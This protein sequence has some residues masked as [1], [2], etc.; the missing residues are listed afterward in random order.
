MLACSTLLKKLMAL[1]ASG[2]DISSTIVKSFSTMPE[3]NVKCS[4]EW[5]EPTKIRYT[6]RLL[7][8]KRSSIHLL[9]SWLRCPPISVATDLKVLLAGHQGF[10]ILIR[11]NHFLRKKLSLDYTCTKKERAC[12]FH[13]LRKRVTG[14]HPSPAITSSRPLKLFNFRRFL[15]EL[16]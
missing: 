16:T 2:S 8:L 10:E 7:S 15:L 13:V 6:G 14:V 4:V 9:A 3:I 11:F 12:T 1:G 5:L